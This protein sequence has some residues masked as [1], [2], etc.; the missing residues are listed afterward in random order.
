[1]NKIIILLISAGLFGILSACATAPAA[2]GKWNANLESP[3]G[4]FRVGFDFQVDGK[5][6]NGMTSNDFMG[7]VPISDGMVKGKEI[8]FTVRYAG[9]PAG[10]MT[11]N[12]TGI[13]EQDQIRFNMVF[14]ENPPP[15]AP[16]N[17]EFTA[18]RVVE[19]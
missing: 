4:P 14:K 16:E 6:L 12:F 8:S 19:E 17:V 18:A 1:M 2:T 10:P 9:G 3:Q 7:P 15:G 5:T 13:V 11:Q